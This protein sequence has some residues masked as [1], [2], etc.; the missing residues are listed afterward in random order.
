ML[1]FFRLLALESGL[2]QANPDY[3]SFAKRPLRLSGTPDFGRG[4]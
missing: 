4:E 2:V 1:K 3:V